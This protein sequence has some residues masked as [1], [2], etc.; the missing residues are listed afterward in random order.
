MRALTIAGA[1]VS[2][3][4]TLSKDW[5]RPEGATI[6]VAQSDRGLQHDTAQQVFYASG[7]ALFNDGGG[8][9][10]VKGAQFCNRWPISALWAC[11]DVERTGPK[12]PAIGQGGTISEKRNGA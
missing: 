2:E 1:L 9:R 8:D 7:R 6:C 11:Y 10:R 5:S 12:P 3:A 4:S